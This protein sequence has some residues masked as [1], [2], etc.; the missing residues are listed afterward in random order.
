MPSESLTEKAIILNPEDDVAI[1]KSGD[2]RGHRPRGRGRPHRGAAG[3]PA[4]AQGRAPERAATARRVRRYGQVIGF[5]TADIEAGDHVH[6]QNLAVRRP[7]SGSTRSAP[8][9]SR[10][11][12]TRPTQM[13]YFDGYKRDD[14]RVGTRNY[15]AIISTVNCSA[16]VSQFVK[17]RFA[18]VQQDYPN[19]DGVLA[20]THKS[21]CG[22][23]SSARTT[24]RS[25]AS[26]PA[27]PST[28]TSPPTS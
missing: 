4:R 2:P 20:I 14:G 11:S 25:S 27:T 7:G 22:T 8:T 15:V 16:S 10:S 24:W 18:D 1:A 5:A 9:C 21:G 28:R 6:T 13:R 12:S 3:H 19:I 23:S 17:E 26:S